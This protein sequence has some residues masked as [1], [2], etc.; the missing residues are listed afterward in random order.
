MGLITIWIYRL[1]DDDADVKH[2]AQELWKE[3]GAKYEEENEDLLKEEI[4][5]EV[6]MHLYPASGTITDC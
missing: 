3:V 4:E 2:R 1:R 6:A 5:C